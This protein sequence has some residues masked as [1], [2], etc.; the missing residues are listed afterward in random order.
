MTSFMVLLYSIHSTSFCFIVSRSLLFPSNHKTKIYSNLREILICN[1]AYPIWDCD[2]FQNES[3]MFYVFWTRKW[4]VSLGLRQSR[5][6]WS[7]FF[8]AD[9]SYPVTT[10][11]H[12]PWLV[13]EIENQLFI[14]VN[15]TFTW[16]FK[17]KYI[18]TIIIWYEIIVNI[19][20][21]LSINHIWRKLT[22][23][24]SSPCLNTYDIK[25]ICDN[26]I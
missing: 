24:F 6:N 3:S 16:P 22:E 14:E 1:I 4:L 8:S 15:F 18:A 11:Y 23:I 25:R 12:F 21:Y 17:S 19:W 5:S 7:N 2:P 13:Q 26:F 10:G 9:C 20:K